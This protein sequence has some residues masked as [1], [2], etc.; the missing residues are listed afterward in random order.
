MITTRET[1]SFPE[2]QAAVTKPAMLASNLVPAET[3][4]QN[5]LPGGNLIICLRRVIT[6]TSNLAPVKAPGPASARLEWELS[7]FQCPHLDGI[8]RCR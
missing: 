3:G 7:I 5:H 2:G 4:T 6:A 1:P 8:T